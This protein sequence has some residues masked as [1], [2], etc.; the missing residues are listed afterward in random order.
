MEEIKLIE[1][2]LKLASEAYYNTN[3]KIMSD[4]EYDELEEKYQQLTGHKYIG[5][6]PPSNL[7]LANIS[8]KYKHLTGS[9]AK[10]KNVDEV[11]VFLNNIKENYGN[12]PNLYIT[13]KYDGNSIEIEYDEN[14][15]IVKALT[16]GKNG[17]GVDL[18]HVFKDTHSLEILGCCG[19]KYEVI[20]TDEDLERLQKDYNLEYV[21]GRSAVA[22]ILGSNDSSELVDYVTLVPLWLQFEN[23]E[24]TLRKYQLEIL[25]DEFGEDYKTIVK[26]YSLLIN[27][28]SKDRTLDNIIQ[29]IETQYKTIMDTIP[30]LNFM[31]DG[32][33]IEIMDKELRSKLGFTSTHP[34][35]AI[36]L[37]FPPQ[38]AKST[39]KAFDYCLGDSGRIT[40]RVWFEPVSF[41]GTTHNKQSLNSYK[42]F[43]ELKL[44]IGSDILVSYNHDCLTYVTPLETENT[45]NL[46]SNWMHPEILCPVCGSKAVPT[47][48]N[49]LL[50]CRNKNCPGSVIGKIQNYLTKMDIKGIKENMIKAF[51]E[52][53]LVNKIED[54]YTMD[55]SKI[56]NIERMGDKVAKNVKKAMQEKIPYD[57]EILGSLGINSCS[58]E[59]TKEIFKTD[60]SLNEMIKLNDD[61]K[62]KLTNINGIADITANY[63]INGIEEN[64][65][66]ILFL[67]N[68]KWLSYREEL[69]KNKTTE[70]SMTIVF[71]GI[72]D[73]ELKEKL[74][75][76]GHKVTGS[77]SAKTDIV[78]TNDTESNTGKVAKAR[79]LGKE[80]ITLDDFKKK[81]DI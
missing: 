48:D 55:Y 29:D 49:T 37:K 42:R 40:P 16:R 4:I 1:E 46:R 32:L 44:S 31:I 72:R 38:E 20:I 54:L 51:K 17:K 33:V 59:T 14:G 56:A 36:A 39:V 18:T 6:E 79:S 9:L 57:Y 34:K 78:I 81:Y 58:L 23:D 67:M 28:E 41:I 68:R 47:D 10:A 35:W 19:I 25:E 45:K 50:Y 22:G 21:N 8:H 24:D 12:I 53:N 80:I 26:Q 62:L 75:L 5:A 3:T 7:G 60:L 13:L 66:L 65:D 74:E 63:I 69:D 15:E 64:K 30:N 52:N 43:L 71:S 61:L 27:G 77:V 70:K 76:K 11:K 73:K 2:K